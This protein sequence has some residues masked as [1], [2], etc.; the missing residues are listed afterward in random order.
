[1]F[2]PQLVAGPI[3]RPQNMLH[4]FKEVHP[5]DPNRISEGLKIIVWGLF[6]KIVVADRLAVYVNA[7]YENVGSEQGWPL[8]LATIFFSFQVYCDFSAYS[9]IAIG[10]AK[11]LG[12]DLMQNFNRPNLS[13]TTTE[14]WKRWHISLST[15]FRDYLFIPMGGSKTN[16]IK[17]CFNLMIV[18]LISG[19]WHGASWNFIIWGAFHGFFLILDRMFLAK[20]L[21]AIGTIPS[22]V[23]TFMVVMI[24]WV[25]FSLE[26]FSNAINYIKIL[27]LF[28]FNLP[29]TLINKEFVLTLILAAFISF[30][31][32][33][34]IGKQIQTTIYK[35]W[36]YSVSQ[37]IIVLF[38]AV[39]LYGI[40][41]SYITATGF[42]PFIYNRF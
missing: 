9:D 2:F 42:N 30:I 15:W 12:F 32:L 11:L 3:E 13:R 40:S 14:Y 36:N 10:S 18:F 31:G 23:F 33:T 41:A 39:V 4:Q 1:M 5:F 21:K 16:L 29:K 24:G 7:S 27:F 26:N 38:C 34:R 19:L 25:F 37:A 20:V 6:K 8:I 17:R 35:E 28:D 22:V